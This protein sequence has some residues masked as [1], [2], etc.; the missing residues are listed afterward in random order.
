MSFLKNEKSLLI[1]YTYSEET[2]YLCICLH[3]YELDTFWILINDGFPIQ[4]TDGIY[5]FTMDAIAFSENRVI[6]LSQQLHGRMLIIYIFD[7]LYNFNHC[8]RIIFKINIIH[9]KMLI[10][11]RYSLIFKYKDTLRLQFENM[12]GKNGF[13]ILG[14]FNSSDPKQIYNIKKT[15]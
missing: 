6:I 10:N 3:N 8:F 11:F 5:Y 7:F 4:I 15:D 2:V 14:Y 12:K 9:L 13:V 1:Y